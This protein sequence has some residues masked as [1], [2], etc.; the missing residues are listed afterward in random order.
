MAGKRRLTDSFFLRYL[1]GVILAVAAL[2]TLWIYTS[3][4]QLQNETD[5]LTERARQRQR[6]ELRERVEQV[7]AMIARER[8]RLDSEVRREIRQRTQNVHK[9]LSEIYRQEKGHMSPE[10]LRRT[11]RSVLRAIHYNQ[12]RGY[13]FATALNGTSEVFPPNPTLEGTS[14]LDVRD[15]REQSVVRDLIR[16][17]EQQQEGFYQYHWPKPQDPDGEYRKISY[18]KYFAPLDWFIGTG[19]Y[20]DDADRALQQELIDRIEQIRFHDGGYIFAANYDG[21]SLVYPAKGRNMIAVEDSDGKKIVQELIALARSGGGFLRYRMPDLEDENP[22]PKISY[23]VGIPEWDWYIGT[24]EAVAELDGE[25]AVML[26]SQRAALRHQL[27]SIGLI[28]TLFLIL[29]FIFASRMGKQLASSFAAF[30]SFFDRA[31]TA[32]E[33]LQIDQQ[34]F[35][36]FQ[37]LGRAANRMLDQHQRLSQEAEEYRDQLRHMV[38]AMPSILAAVNQQ[39]QVR[40]WNSFAE[41]TTGI[42]EEEAIGQPLDNLLPY[43]GEILPELLEKTGQGEKVNQLKI[44]EYQP[45]APGN[46]LISAYPLAISNHRHSVIRID[47]ITDR[48]RIEEMMVQTEKMQSMGDL[49]AGIA[50]EI[51]NPLSIICQSTQNTE[52]RLAP[53]L[54]ANHRAASELD[55]D[56]KKVDHYIRIREIPRFL[57]NINSAVERI[58]DIIKSISNF[59]TSSTAT[60]EFCKIKE[61]VDDALT[62]AYNDFSLKKKYDFRNVTIDIALPD[63]LPMVPVNRSEMEQ[64]IFNLVKNAGQAM[65]EARD[66]NPSPQI[67]IS[68]SAAGQLLKLTITDNGPGIPEDIRSRVLEPFFTTKG[69]GIGSGLGLSVSYYIIVKRHQGSFRIDSHSDRGTTFTMTLPLKSDLTT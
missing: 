20:L 44:S 57:K 25:I 48:V 64:V 53:D 58:A 2:G 22:E 54:P 16:I 9:T 29:G 15:L 61:V 63:D 38:D 18:I 4:Q 31:A 46:K 17:A 23:A 33:P 69:V 34:P 19:E 37:E 28:I 26:A 11:L 40:Q 45:E 5:L 51:N 12:G 30:Q 47:D 6:A 32:G 65:A 68:A 21:L 42:P 56:L 8:R 36:E 60:K 62:L 14:L 35:C 49:A 39:G 43:I 7:A 50:H 10:Q 52:R 41:E 59:S 24:G 27:G 66:K 67:R 3:H 1:C 55:L 13:F